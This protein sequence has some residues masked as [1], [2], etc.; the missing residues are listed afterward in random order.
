M[1]INTTDGTVAVVGAH[2]EAAGG[3]MAGAAYI[4]KRNGTS[5]SQDAKIVADD[6]A[7][8]DIYG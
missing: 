6:A 2:Q 3:T 1:A 7:A 5:W 8:Y 4:F